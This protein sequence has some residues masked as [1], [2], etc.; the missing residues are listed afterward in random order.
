[1]TEPALPS[2]DPGVLSAIATEPDE[3]VRA[4]LRSEAQVADAAVLARP[5][6]ADLA[7]PA[8]PLRQGDATTE[9]L[10]LTL[11]LTNSERL[12]LMTALEDWEAPNPQRDAEAE[13][14]HARLNT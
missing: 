7:D 13:D 9:P 4:L 5:T 11:H 10:V 14:L 1:M 12:T 8:H 3:K 6:M 2:R